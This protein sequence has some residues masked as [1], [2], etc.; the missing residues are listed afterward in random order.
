MSLEHNCYRKQE[1]LGQSTARLLL[2]PL[3]TIGLVNP[4]YLR[5]RPIELISMQSL[6][7]RYRE[8]YDLCQ[9]KQGGTTCCLSSPA[10]RLENT[11]LLIL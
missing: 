6:G 1:I 11:K 8:Q 4:G 2:L 9:N 3:L 7:E 10:R 5:T